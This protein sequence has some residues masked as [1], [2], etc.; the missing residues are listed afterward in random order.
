[1]WTNLKKFKTS[2]RQKAIGIWS[3]EDYVHEKGY[4]PVGNGEMKIVKKKESNQ[5]KTNNCNI[6]GNI[7]SKKEKIY[8][9]PTGQYYE[10]GYTRGLVL[11]CKR[12]RRKQGFAHPK[13]RDR[14]KN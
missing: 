2:A 1:M 8:H 5:L 3:I 9:L 12:R 14:G 6:K 11:L 7:N 4:E 13:G 10:C